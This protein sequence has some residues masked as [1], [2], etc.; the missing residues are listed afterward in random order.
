MIHPIEAAVP[1]LEVLLALEPRELGARILFILRTSP[2]Q[3]QGAG[4]TLQGFLHGLEPLGGHEQGA[5]GGGRS[6]QIERAVGEAWHWLLREGLLVPS[7]GMNGAN[8]WCQFSRRAEAFEEEEDLKHLQSPGML[9]KEALHPQLLPAVWLD[10][11]KGEFDDA[12]GRAMKRVEIR[13]R[14]A[15]GAKSGL[16]GVDLARFAFHKEN[17]P[18]T[19]LAAEGGEREAVA[20]LFAGAFGVLKNPQGHRD[21]NLADP[22]QVA[23]IIMFASYLLHFIDDRVR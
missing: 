13:L 4:A 10:Y 3:M 16:V 5:Y 8:G 6:H 9:P 19:D 23:S 7:P 17:G 2:G 21:V 22:A 11:M 12:V 14:E 1:S 18:L 15:S 20:H